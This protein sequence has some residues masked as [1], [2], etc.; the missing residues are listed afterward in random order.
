MEQPDTSAYMLTGKPLLASLWRQ[1]RWAFMI[2]A[3][4]IASVLLLL[5]TGHTDILQA[6]SKS[7]GS[8]FLIPYIA[9]VLLTIGLMRILPPVLPLSNPLDEKER[10][11]ATKGLCPILGYALLY[12]V[13]LAVIGILGLDYIDIGKIGLLLLPSCILFW[14][15]GR[16]IPYNQFKATRFAVWYWLGPICIALFYCIAS[17]IPPFAIHGLRGSLPDKNLGVVLALQAV[18]TFLNAGLPEEVF[19]R[20][21]LQTRLEFFLGRW[22]GIALTSLLFA[23]MHFPT[24]LVSWLGTT[25]IAAFDIILAL[26]AVIAIQGSGGFILGYLWSRYRNLWVNVLFH[27]AL[28]MVPIFVLLLQVR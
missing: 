4:F 21:L 6:S 26:A 14:L 20:V 3:M 7:G 23:L 13:L 18:I 19:Y 24:R 8:T 12:P 2:I 28:D 25:G 10:S 22:N 27:T 5:F 9:L 1:H 15:Y 11:R 16:K 17:S